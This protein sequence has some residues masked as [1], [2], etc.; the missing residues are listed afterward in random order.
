MA[1]NPAV[2]LEHMIGNKADA[3]AKFIRKGK[4]GD[5]RNY[6]SQDLEKKFDEWS[7]L[8]TKGTGLSFEFKLPG[9]EE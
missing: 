4:V 2:N 3:D 7:E 8:N 9:L 6:M 1:S 5:W